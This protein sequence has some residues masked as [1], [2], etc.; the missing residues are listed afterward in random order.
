M[1]EGCWDTAD[2]LAT[3]RL[4]VSWMA[5]S[6]V[7]WKVNPNHSLMSFHVFVGLP[8]LPLPH[9][10]PRRMVLESRVD[11][12][13]WPYCFR[14]LTIMSRS[15]WLPVVANIGQFLKWATLPHIEQ[16]LAL[17]PTNNEQNR[18]LSRT[19]GLL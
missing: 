3:S 5:A 14:F 7:S 6:W 13:T 8:L 1:T 10:V 17:C 12:V 9:T 4:Q 15:L 2:E 18:P 19:P 11:S 16:T